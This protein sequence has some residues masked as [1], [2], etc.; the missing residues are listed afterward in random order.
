LQRSSALR[1]RL[2]VQPLEG[3]LVP[4]GTIVATLSPA[5]LL[6]LIGDDDANGVSIKV[7]ASVTLTQLGGT[8]I[9][10]TGVPAGIAVKS[11]K[12]DLKGG[13]DT[14]T[15]DGAT[16]FNVSG[17]AAITLGDGNNTLTLVTTG[18]I[19]LGSLAITGGDGSD[20]V[21]V[22]GAA[23]SAIGG[24][25]K[26]KF[27][28][29]GSDTTLT[30]VKF[31]ALTIAAGDAP[32]TANDVTC[33]GVTI[34]KAF[35]AS[36]G[37]SF[38]GIISFDTC[39]ISGGIKADGYSVS[40]LL[41]NTTVVK[42]VGIK[43]LYDSDL[44]VDGATI[45]GN[46]AMTS[47]HTNFDASG[48]ATKITGNLALTATAWTSTSFS[49][50]TAS[51]V[52]GDVK[53]KGGWF[54][55]S[56]VTDANFKADKGVSLKLGDG[57][58]VITIGDGSAA[59]PVLGKLQIQTGA[60][61]DFITLDHLTLSGAADIKTGG[62]ADTLSIEDASSFALAFKA[63][64]GAGNDTISIA[65][66]IGASGPVTFSGKTTILAGLGNDNLFL[67]L[68]QVANGGD[69]N[70]RSVFTDPTSVIDGGLGI[71]SY[72]AS[73]GQTTTVSTPN[74]I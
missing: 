57:D 64:M 31:S 56:F 44:E 17:P 59:V 65:Q 58:N 70:S 52:T 4:N 28:N 33:T 6:T 39:T 38:P 42:G 16:D 72:D 34:D 21:T 51:E 32:T 24:S 73:T 48:A 68:D 15:I 37:N 54:N 12:A 60:G 45:T 46:V 25:S 9:N 10:A 35:K 19:T 27:A 5:G 53:I 29:G 74:W 8:T 14:L 13:D 47:P 1:P 3:R 18:K 66:N 61:G 26:F 41:T 69:P 43:T 62:G 30:G 67:G 71:N 2:A 49:T 11:I 23:G 22:N 36:L 20:T 50:G 63:D 7:G 55:D 40:A